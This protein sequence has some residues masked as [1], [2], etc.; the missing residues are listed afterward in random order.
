MSNDLG[1]SDVRKH[2]SSIKEAY[3]KNLV[4][5][6]PNSPEAVYFR[7]EE[8]VHL[9]FKILSEIDVL[10]GK[11]ILDFG[12]GN[13]LLLSYLKSKKIHCEYHGWDISEKMIDIARQRHPDGNFRVVDVLHD[14]LSE[15]VDY[16]DL[17]LIS[18]V[19]NGMW[20]AQSNIAHERWI[21]KTLLSLWALSKVGISVNFL[22]KFVDW[23]DPELYYCSVDTAISFVKGLSKRFVLRHDYGLWEFTLYIYKKIDS[24]NVKVD[25]VVSKD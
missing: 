4:D 6:D 9:R 12:C 21:Q 15:Y 3:E 2:V 11:K 25:R 24:P 19:F 13:A 1:N 17:V 23:E 10:D 16:F 8:K 20:G 22:T 5:K 14:N 18:G 7:G